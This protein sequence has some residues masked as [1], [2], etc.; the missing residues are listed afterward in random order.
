MKICACCHIEKELDCFHSNK[1]RKDGKN[2]YCKECVKEK[3][4]QYNQS[5]K[6][7]Q[8]KKIYNSK[9]QETHKE[10]I[11]EYLKEYRKS[12]KRKK[13]QKEYDKSEKR[14]KYFKDYNEKNKEKYNKY[15][16]QK[17]EKNP[18]FKL[19]KNI[20]CLIK[21]SFKNKGFQKNT[22]TID[23][24]GCSIEEFKQ[25]IEKQFEPWMSWENRGKYNGQEKY[26]WDIDHIIPLASAKT[27]EELLKL[28][29][30][31]NLQPL[32]S[33][34]NRVIKRDKINYETK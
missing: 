6:G 4:K 18:L 1:S 32:D 30:Y 11:K 21:Y 22:K 7:K 25:Y 10:H 8:I 28:N 12:E 34:I 3:N 2:K 16:N 5:E 27:E 20:R 9:Y 19:K 26:G 31:T 29:H 15:I 33:Y 17:L 14:K 24:L 23:I 13:Y